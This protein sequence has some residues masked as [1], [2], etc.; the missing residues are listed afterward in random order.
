[1]KQLTRWMLFLSIIIAVLSCQKQT[2]KWQG[3]IE[4]ENDIIVVKNPQEPMYGEEIFSLEEE[5]SIGVVEGKEEFLFSEI[6]RIAVDEQGRIYV[7]D[8]KEH[9][10]K[11]FD[12]NGSFVKKFGKKGQGPGEFQF[13]FE[14]FILGK[15]EI[16]VQSVHFSLFSR[17]GDY[18]RSISTTPT[19]LG[20]AKM[21]SEGNIVGLVVVMEEENPRYELKKFDSEMNLLHSLGSSSIP[22]LRADTFN[23][24][25]PRLLWCIGLNDQIICGTQDK[26]KITIFDSEGKATRK[27]SKEFTPIKID[28]ADIDERT[29]GMLPEMKSRMTIPKYHNAFLWISADDEGKIFVQTWERTYNRDGYLF[30]IFD[31]EGKYLAKVPIPAKSTKYPLIFKKNKLFTIEEDEEGFQVVKRYKVTWNID[32]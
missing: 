10:V 9:S 3:T 23:P 1:M 4:E 17:D 31:Q 16:V 8:L 24:F 25:F 27:I 32:L 26:Y 11:I 30:D 29:E 2:T 5:L 6:R 14:I 20:P 7:L 22:K 15:D 18:K 12:E 19:R 13:P 28:Q 21:D